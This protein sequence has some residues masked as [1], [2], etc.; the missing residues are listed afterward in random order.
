M[1][2]TMHRSRIIR[3]AA[4]AM[5]V[6]LS[7]PLLSGAV[8]G[9]SAPHVTAAGAEVIAARAVCP[10]CSGSFAPQTYHASL[11]HHGGVA[12][13][14]VHVL[15]GGSVHVVDV[16]VVGGAVVAQKLSSEQPP[17]SPSSRSSSGLAV[18]GAVVAP[19]G[20]GDLA[21]AAPAR[22]PEGPAAAE[23]EGSKPLNAPV[24]A[25]GLVYGQKL[26]GAPAAF[27]AVVQAAVQAAGGGTL[28]WVKF[29]HG[30]KGVLQMK[31]K[32]R[33][34]DGRTRAVHDVFSTTGAVLQ[35][36]VQTDN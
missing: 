22:Q 21:E 2:D 23:T 30:G 16:A 6:V 1:A 12:V 27:A 18:L 3:S 19:T 32:L 34:A 24:P 7:I 4:T 13:W 29:D 9:A 28:Q 15:Y 25:R 20:Q 35:Q 5:A 11:D 33:L 36:R 26:T 10:G 17:A 31:V 8:S 14:D